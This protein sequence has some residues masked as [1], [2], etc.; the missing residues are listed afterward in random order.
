MKSDVRL[1]RTAVHNFPGMSF[2]QLQIQTVRLGQFP[3]HWPSRWRE[4]NFD[5]AV[6]I[7]EL[8]K[9]CALRLGSDF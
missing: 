9:W 7:K 5:V 1:R 3:R 4:K 2:A 6:F 8:H